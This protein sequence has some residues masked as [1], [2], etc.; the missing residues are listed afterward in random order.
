MGTPDL[1]LSFEGGEDPEPA[2][3]ILRTLADA[4]LQLTFFLDGLWAE[5][6]PELIRAIGAAGHE[7]GNH[8]HGHPDWTTL[9]DAAIRADLAR[10]DEI[11]RRLGG[12]P[13]KPW[14][15]P[16]KGA[17]DARVQGVL[18]SDG[19]RAVNPEPLDA[20]VHTDNAAAG[21]TARILAGADDGEVLTVHTGR[22]ATAQAVAAALPELR[23]RGFRV[24]SISALERQPHYAPR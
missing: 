20:R 18:A 5:E 21:I 19:Y 3:A 17:L 7:L 12:R 1:A 8:G 9:D 15:L 4:E 16:P 22:W 23:A 14:A 6:N 24:R 2:Y 11:A 10:V 13:A